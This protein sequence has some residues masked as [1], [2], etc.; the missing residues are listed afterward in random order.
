MAA[1]VTDSVAD[2]ILEE[3][4]IPYSVNF[5]G[6]SIIFTD[7]NGYILEVRP[8]DA[9]TYSLIG[10]GS[11]LLGGSI[12]INPAALVI[13]AVVLAAGV[14]VDTTVGWDVVAEKCTDIY[15]NLTD[16]AKEELETIYE[17]IRSDT[18][19]DGSFS[20]SSNL[21][22]ELSSG[23]SDTFYND[24][25][26][27]IEQGLTFSPS[28][29]L[30]YESTVPQFGSHDDPSLV[31]ANLC[32]YPLTAD[33]VTIKDY[34]DPDH[35]KDTPL[36]ISLGENVFGLSD[37]ALELTPIIKLYNEVTG[38]TLTFGM[39]A[40]V[41]KFMGYECSSYSISAPYIRTFTDS[42]GRVYHKFGFYISKHCLVEDHCLYEYESTKYFAETNSSST[43]DY[44]YFMF[45]NSGIAGLDDVV[46]N[47]QN[48]DVATG[49][50]MLQ[51][52]TSTIALNQSALQTILSTME[53]S[54]GLAPGIDAPTIPDEEDTIYLPPADVLDDLDKLTYGGATTGEWGA[55]T[56]PDNPTVPDTESTFWEKL[57]GWLSDIVDGIKAIPS[58]IATWG[59]EVIDA[60]AAIPD[61]FSEWWDKVIT[62]VEAIPGSIADWWTEAIDTVKELALDLEGWFT[63]VIDNIKALP[64]TIVDGLSIFIDW[65]KEGVIGAL[66]AAFIPSE[67]FFEDF[68]SDLK[69]S[70]ENRFG[71]LTF[72]ISVIYDFLD[73]LLSVGHTEPIF[74]W[75]SWS[76]QGTE[77]IAAGSYNLN[78]ITKNSTF[79]TI[80][81]IYLVVVDCFLIFLFLGFIQRK[82]R[83]IISS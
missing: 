30:D 44:S 81:N 35:V 12:A 52:E 77:L 58:T 75:N 60:V 47:R 55:T 74:R 66:E 3:L 10:G 1:E 39:S 28:V 72:P 48:Y 46:F 4:E 41:G 27:L 51:S 83:S 31:G 54:I 36:K 40:G 13:V 8:N 80:Y 26:T 22:A 63:D 38:A 16:A 2:D 14:V 82:Y 11:L 69:A 18:N 5:A 17:N 79:N 29:L 56:T 37:S 50:W 59:E 68:F 43:G 20:L 15:N 78:D 71:L 73:S 33:P 70:F 34:S 9:S 76:Y 67:G 61:A 64:Q 65:I 7:D 53:Y 6:D 25:G 45:T 24:D 19:S 23:F 49:K 32:I 57:W 62:A 42:K 21:S